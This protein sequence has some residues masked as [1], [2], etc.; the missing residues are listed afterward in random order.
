MKPVSLTKV[1]DELEMMGDGITAYISTKTG[2]M[3]VV[4]DDL[5][6]MLE[7][8]DPP[9]WAQ[10]IIPEVRE[11]LN[12]DEFIQLPDA[13]EIHEYD[14]MQNFCYAVQDEALRNEL[15]DLIRGSGAFRRFKGF[16]YQKE[17]EKDWYA[18]RESAIRQIAR[19]FLEARNIPFIDDSAGI[20]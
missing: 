8:D 10:D 13:W 18:Y 5:E 2:H 17:I 20:K 15:L 9:E 1:A 14:I 4:T 12:S 11:A 3:V 19:E 7:E 6:S 16:V